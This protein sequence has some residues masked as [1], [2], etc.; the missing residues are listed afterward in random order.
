[1]AARNLKLRGRQPAQPTLL[2]AQLCRRARMLGDCA[3]EQRRLCQTVT[4]CALGARIRWCARAQWVCSQ[5]SSVRASTQGSSVRK[6]SKRAHGCA[7]AGSCAIRINRAEMSPKKRAASAYAAV[8]GA[9]ERSLVSQMVCTAVC[10]AVSVCA[11]R[12]TW[13]YKSAGR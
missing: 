9:P 1:M 10:G 2:S 12:Q 6:Q 5:Q 4:G 3:A 8:A 13:S 7:V 11:T